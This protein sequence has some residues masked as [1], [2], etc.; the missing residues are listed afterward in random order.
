MA[1]IVP[2]TGYS[3]IAATSVRRRAATSVRRRSTLEE[4][5]GEYE[6]KGLTVAEIT[7]T[8]RGNRYTYARVWD[9]KKQKQRDIYLGP[10]RPQRVR[11]ILTEDDIRQLD[12]L[13]AFLENSRHRTW[14]DLLDRIR[15]AWRHEE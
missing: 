10:V 5:K 9:P 11:G 12:K 15:L 4:L 2:A 14:A 7:R 13:H 3:R 8:V 1:K 6:P